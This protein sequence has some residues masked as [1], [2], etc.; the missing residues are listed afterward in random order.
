[1]TG[2]TPTNTEYSGVIQY[3][4]AENSVIELGGNAELQE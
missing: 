1:M 2:L 4:L 3:L